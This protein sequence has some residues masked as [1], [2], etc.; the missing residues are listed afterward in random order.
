MKKIIAITA[1]LVLLAS[2]GACSIA[3]AEPMTDPNEPSAYGRENT[4]DSVQTSAGVIVSG[5]GKQSVLVLSEKEGLLSLD[6]GKTA[7]TVNSKDSSFDK[8]KNGMTVEFTY[9]SIAETYPGQAVPKTLGASETKT[10]YNDIC[11]MY[12]EIIDTLWKTDIALNENG[13]NVYLDLSEAPG[14]TDAQ[15][16][17]VEY[18][19]QSVTGRT[20]TAAT[21]A[22][23][24]KN[25]TFDKENL[26]IKDGCFIKIAGKA[27]NSSKMTLS[28]QKY[29]SGLGAIFFDDCTAKWNSKG[30]WTFAPGTFAIS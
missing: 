24:E 10:D 19:A 11:S 3:Q 9:D 18:L 8:L 23:L 25:G 1:C 22:E 6:L 4:G 27:E 5:G 26:Y 12:V 2:L 20:V 29:V 14:L 28:A 7:V 17:A 16:Q 30:E 21:M 15:K 13:E